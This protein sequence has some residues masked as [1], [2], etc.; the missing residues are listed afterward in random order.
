MTE[1]WHDLDKVSFV[2]FV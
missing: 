2:L 1:Q